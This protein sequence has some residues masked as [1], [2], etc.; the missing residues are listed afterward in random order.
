MFMKTKV[1][2]P[3]DSQPTTF[4]SWV[5]TI[6]SPKPVSKWLV[7]VVLYKGRQVNLIFVCGSQTT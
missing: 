1:V 5:P 2:L 6:G 3:I 7:I 4:V